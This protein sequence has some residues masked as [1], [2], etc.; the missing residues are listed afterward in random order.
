MLNKI[1]CDNELYVELLINIQEPRAYDRGWRNSIVVSVD[2]DDTPD[3]QLV[4][5]S[6]GYYEYKTVTP[7]QIN[8]IEIESSLWDMG[9]TIDISLVKEGSYYESIY[10]EFPDQIDSVGMLNRDENI[11]TRYIMAGSYN[12]PSDIVERVEVLEES[13]Q[14]KLT[15]GQGVSIASDNTIK[16]TNPITYGTTDIGVGAPLP[17]GTIYLVYED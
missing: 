5:Y 11:S 3:Q 14:D 6:G 15:A 13:K 10:I 12:D 4:I 7:N 1:V 9:G 8:D 2:A 16:V 17:T